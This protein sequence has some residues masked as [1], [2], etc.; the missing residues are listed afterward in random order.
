MFR[1]IGSELKKHVLTGISYMIPLVIAGAVIMAIARVGGSFYGITD[2]WDPK[3]A[4]STNGIISLLHS[5]DGFGGLALSMMFP[6]IAAF[7]AYSISDKLGIAPGLVGGLLARDIGA[8][9]L[10]ALAAGLIAGYTCL[11]IKKYVKLPKSA[12]SIVPVFLVPVFGTL[13]TVLI[14]NYV[15]GIPFAD[16]NKALE[17]W[18]NGMSGTNQILMAAIIGAMVG[19]DLGGPVNKAAVTTAMALLTSGIYAPNTAAQ[20]AI[21]IPPLGLG[22]ATLIARRKYNTEMR[23][24]GKSSLIMGLV[25]ISEGAIP[26]AVESPLKVIP[27]T[28]IGSAIGGALAVGLGAIN[29]APISGFYGWFT[30][31]NWWFYI[32]AIAVGTFVVAGMSVALRK[33]SAGQEESYT[34]EEDDFDEAEWEA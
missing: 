29:Q 21:I 27:A 5:L 7:I 12:A 34:V 4:D 26:F 13:I 17:T 15:V 16:L 22:L 24:A 18:L 32:L 19:F 9:F 6:V 23:E 11:L 28:V 30:V 25:G 33:D 3:Y 8:G 20:V 31:Q 2:I 1:K 10:G 14:I